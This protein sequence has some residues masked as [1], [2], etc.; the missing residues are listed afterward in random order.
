MVIGKNEGDS[1]LLLFAFTFVV[2]TCG[3]LRFLTDMVSVCA[4][5]LNGNT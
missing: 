5:V 1:A 3:V 4:N 2:V